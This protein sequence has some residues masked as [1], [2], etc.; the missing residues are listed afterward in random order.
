[1]AAR[2]KGPR[3]KPFKEGNDPRRATA[4][5]WKPGQSGNPTGGSRWVRFRVLL[6]EAALKPASG[7]AKDRTRYQ[8][9]AEILFRMAEKGN[10]AAIKE[11][12]DRLEGRSPQPITGEDLG[13][14]KTEHKHD[15]SKLEKKE[16]SD[17]VETLRK[18][19]PA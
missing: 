7:K 12:L 10:L 3:G 17:L 18:M 8:E 1:M 6:K 16:I 19:V 15:F 14:I 13:P 11:T 9:L 5:L 2:K 4:P